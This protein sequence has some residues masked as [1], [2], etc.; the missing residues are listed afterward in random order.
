MRSL[1]A[2][3]LIAVLT[4]T[5]CETAEEQRAESA[6]ATQGRRSYPI[7]LAQPSEQPTR[8]KGKPSPEGKKFPEEDLLFHPSARCRH[9]RICDR[10]FSPPHIGMPVLGAR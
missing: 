8:I 6:S 3:V 10:A 9:A 2:A 4:T 1:N 5:Q 7:E